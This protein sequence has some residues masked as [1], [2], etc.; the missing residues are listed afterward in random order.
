MS[1]KTFLFIIL[2]ILLGIF[3]YFK[4]QASGDLNSQFNQTTRFEL[5]RHP[6]LRTIFGLHNDG[7]ARAEYLD[8]KGLIVLQWF[9]PNFGE[10]QEGM[11]KKFGEL[12]SGYTGRPVRLAF[13]NNITEQT[14]KLENL[15]ALTVKSSAQKTSGASVFVVVFTNDYTPRQETELSTTY[16]ESRIVLSLEAHKKFLQGNSL[17]LADYLFS[18]LLHEFG[19]QIGLQHNTDPNCIMNQNAGIDGKPLEFYGASSPTDF[20]KTEKEQIKALKLKYQ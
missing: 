14:V 5:A 6:F 16:K 17:K 20:C 11:V 4:L 1:F 9:E 10:E 15:D 7:D 19:H 12:V 18:S 3:T 2:V 8:D 13:G